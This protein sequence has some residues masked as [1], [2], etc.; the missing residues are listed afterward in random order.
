MLKKGGGGGWGGQ[1]PQS[2]RGFILWEAWM[3]QIAQFWPNGGEAGPGWELPMQIEIVILL[4]NQ[5]HASSGLE[6]LE[7]I[8]TTTSGHIY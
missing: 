8:L 6:N 5:P 3:Q 2:N 7:Y 1:I 4:I